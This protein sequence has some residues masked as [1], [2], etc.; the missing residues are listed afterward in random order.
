MLVVKFYQNFCPIYYIKG[1]ET[2]TKCFNQ[3]GK[4]LQFNFSK[5]PLNHKYLTVWKNY[6]QLRDVPNRKRNHRMKNEMKSC[7]NFED[8]LKFI[9]EEN[10]KLNF[11]S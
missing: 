2:R 9:E 4:Y 3:V 10:R 6:M 5:S 8:N 11:V 1:D 7:D